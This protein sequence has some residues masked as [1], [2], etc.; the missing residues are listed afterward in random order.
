VRT[1]ALLALLGAQRAEGGEAPNLAVVTPPAAKVSVDEAIRTGVAFLVAHQ[2]KDGS[3][4]HHTSGR[5]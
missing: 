3:F 4:G 1:I 2:N 5:T